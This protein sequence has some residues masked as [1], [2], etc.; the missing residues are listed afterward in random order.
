MLILA[1]PTRD[2]AL[3]R[4]DSLPRTVLSP[5]QARQLMSASHRFHARW[6]WPHVETRDRAILELLYGTGIRRGECV[7]LDIADL[8]LLQGELLVRNG[9]GRKDRVVPIPAR[10][11]L[12]LDIYLR[13]AR[14]AF[15]KDHRMPRSSP[16]GW[17][18][19]SSQ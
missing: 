8:N 10:A 16:R 14:P 6:W 3:P 11:A 17:A 19:G 4:P 7:R 12:A 2:V 9:K 13:E 1:D 5:T 15:V 18:T